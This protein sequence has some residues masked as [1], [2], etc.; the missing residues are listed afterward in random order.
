MDDSVTVRLP[1]PSP[2]HDAVHLAPL[3]RLED[4]E[5]EEECCQSWLVRDTQSPL[6]G[7]TT[8]TF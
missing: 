7:H 5:S 1:Q 4:L 8:A 2:L 6:F 3:Y